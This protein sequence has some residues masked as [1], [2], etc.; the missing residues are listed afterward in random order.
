VSFD[1]KSS[2]YVRGGEPF[3]VQT[4]AN[5]RKDLLMRHLTV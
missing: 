2:V 5:F 3:L 1:V 4:T